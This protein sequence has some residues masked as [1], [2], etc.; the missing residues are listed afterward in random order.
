MPNLDEYLVAKSGVRNRQKAT[1][2]E[3]LPRAGLHARLGAVHG[4]T[5]RQ[6]LRSPLTLPVVIGDEFT[7]EEEYGWEDFTT[8]GA[9]EH[10]SPSP[11]EHARPQAKMSGETMT[12][13]WSPHWLAAPHQSPEKVRRELLKIGRKHAIFDLLII[14]KPSAD[15][16][17]FSGYATI[18]RMARTI[19]R[20]EAD[21]RYY[22][23]DISEY[24]PMDT[25]QKRHRFGPRLPTTHALDANDTLRSL[26]RELL[27]KEQYWRLIAQVNGIDN[28]GG[29]DPIVN[30]K[31]YKVG[32]RLK[33]PYDLI[34]GGT[35]APGPDDGAAAAS[36][37]E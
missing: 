20:G 22:S 13:T 35:T 33:I 23:F 9:G 18:R 7:V 10:S 16:A 12:L 19:K 1:K 6:V 15:Y 3:P 36:S 28:W 2:H 37:G 27:G 4:L 30:S 26:A 11:G 21:T 34:S 8:V 31:R 5:P 24:R 32:D 25:G 17:E 29:N 14:N